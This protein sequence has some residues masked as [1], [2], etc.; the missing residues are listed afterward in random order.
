MRIHYISKVINRPYPYLFS[1]K[2]NLMIA[3]ILGLVV[4][5]INVLAMDVVYVND[6][7]L[8]SKQ[9][10]CILAGLTTFCSILFVIEIIPRFCFTIDVKE[11]WTIGKEFFLIISLLFFIAVFNNVMSF[12]ISKVH[13]PSNIW[14]R[15]FNASFYVLAIGFV[16]VL[17]I[18]WFNYTMLLKENLRQVSLYNEQLESEVKQNDGYEANNISIQTNNKNEILNINLNTFLF[19]RA[20]G[21]YTD[22]F[23]KNLNCVRNI[24]YRITIQQLEEA[25]KNYPFVISTHRSYIINIKNISSTSGNAR[26]YRI[27]FDD[28][29]I[30]VP[31]SRNKFK[32]FKEAF[33]SR[34]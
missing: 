5:F 11:N 31:V 27:N 34:L 23:I 20:E 29:V 32:I 16:P 30:Q 17:L 26:N 15:F 9:G 28:V 7:F 33:N 1:P 19:A 6:N 8:F 22:I 2:R 21:N 4:Y 24:P 25:L 13:I 12:F 10:V 3:F 14:F 18:I